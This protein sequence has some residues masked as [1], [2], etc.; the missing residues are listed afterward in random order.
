M[1]VRNLIIAIGA[2]AGISFAASVLTFDAGANAAE[3]K[4]LS[5]NV[6]TG[7]IDVI[8]RDF[9]RATGHKVIVDYYT[10]GAVRRR[11]AEGEFADVAIL[12]RPV[13]DELLKQGKMAPGSIVEIAR[14]AV[15][16]TIRAG[17]PKPD[18]SSVDSFKRALLAAKSITYPDPARGGASGILLTR[19]FERLGITQEMK[20]KTKFPPPGRFVPSLVASGEAEIGMTQPMEF[21]AEPEVQF[22]GLLPAELQSPADFAFAASITANAK[23]PQ[24]AKALIQFFSGPGA[25][26]VFK[27]KGMEP[28]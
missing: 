22:V 18:I 21:Y 23:E 16:V 27:A 24:A 5:A 13:M 28:G 4:V 12:T 10:I 7:V 1:M 17:A 26:S 11:I 20:L 19:V 9:E 15:G 14:S 2:T 3:I 8:A 6:F 25:A